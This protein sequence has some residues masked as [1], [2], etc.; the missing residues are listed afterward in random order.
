MKPMNIGLARQV[1]SSDL[2]YCIFVSRIQVGTEL[3][4]V[5]DRP[6][7][8][9]AACRYQLTTTT[10]RNA[11]VVRATRTTHNWPRSHYLAATA[12]LKT[13]Q[14]HPL[15]LHCCCNHSSKWNL[16]SSLRKVAQHCASLRKVAQVCA[17]LRKLFAQLC[18]TFAQ[19]CAKL[20][21]L[22][23][24]GC[25]VTR[26]MRPLRQKF[27]SLFL[28][29]SRLIGRCSFSLHGCMEIIKLDSKLQCC[30][31]RQ[32]VS[33]TFIL[34]SLSTMTS[35]NAFLVTVSRTGFVHLE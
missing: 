10:V 18:A 28:I 22:C 9:D 6:S 8:A 21:E 35:K 33:K 27:W 24:S 26:F 1:K 7:C 32:I 19:L 29:F 20:F 3:N 31:Q 15:L 34:S 5:K 17:T 11:H 30:L 12:F 2:G 16:R 4:W 25:R 23:C 13:G 14:L